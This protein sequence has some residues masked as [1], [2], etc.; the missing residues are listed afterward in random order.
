MPNHAYDYAYVYGVTKQTFYGK[1]V[2]GYGKVIRKCYDGFVFNA[3]VGEADQEEWNR[4][5]FALPTRVAMLFDMNKQTLEQI[6]FADI[7][8]GDNVFIQMNNGNA[9][10]VVVYR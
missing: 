8:A 1:D 3:H 9:P 2:I 10:G 4:R 5:I 7:Q 6:T